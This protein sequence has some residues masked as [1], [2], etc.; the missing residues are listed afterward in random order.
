LTSVTFVTF[1][2]LAHFQS[3]KTSMPPKETGSST[4]RTTDL[5]YPTKADGT[6]DER[7]TAPQFVKKD[8]TRDMRTT[9]TGKR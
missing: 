6:K 3:H 2:S 8:G 5:A 4:K 9:P 1:W 7:Y